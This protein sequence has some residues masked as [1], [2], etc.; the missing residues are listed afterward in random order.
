MNITN[1]QLNNA[2]ID[3]AFKL[4]DDNNVTVTVTAS[5]FDM[6]DYSN[7]KLVWCHAIDRTIE[8]E[9]LFLK[10]EYV[11]EIFSAGKQGYESTSFKNE[12]VQKEG[13]VLI[14]VTCQ[15]GKMYARVNINTKK[16]F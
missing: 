10:S 15:K 3:K 11:Q 16:N 6:Q 14:S 13:H 4:S 9:Q 12:T 2:L 8:T 1:P 5:S 7:P